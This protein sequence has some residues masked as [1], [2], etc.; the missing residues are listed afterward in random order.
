MVSVLFINN[1]HGTRATWRLSAY[2]RRL[3]GFILAF[4]DQKGWC[5][6]SGVTHFWRATSRYTPTHFE[7][8]WC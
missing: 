1:A 3:L 6:L 7:I 5:N 4:V 8:A 2:G